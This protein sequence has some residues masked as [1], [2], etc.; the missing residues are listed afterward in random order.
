MSQNRFQFFR[1]LAA[2]IAILYACV[3]L[4]AFSGCNL[5]MVLL[6]FRPRDVF[7]WN[8]IVLGAVL[9]LL[10][11]LAA[12]YW[13]KYKAPQPTTPKRLLGLR[14]CYAAVWI[15]LA[16]VSFTADWTKSLHWV[17]INLPI[18]FDRV[19]TVSGTFIAEFSA[20]Y[21]VEIELERNLPIR[22]LESLTGSWVNPDHPAPS[23]PPRPEIKLTVT[24]VTPD[25]QSDSWSTDYWGTKVGLSLGRF[26]A[27][28][29]QKYTVT[30]KVTKTSPTTQV[31]NPHLLVALTYII[32]PR[33][34]VP[35]MIAQVGG[36]IALIVGMTLLIRAI[37]RFRRERKMNSITSL[38]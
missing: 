32:A 37:L 22:D 14:L 3:F 19:N 38:E 6:T 34:Y 36:M 20:A 24:N 27:V 29:G 9:G 23:S 25:D 21:Y 16:L 30:A 8:I 13:D 1:F 7:P 11:G 26:Q 10:A 18:R 5:G 17:P 33:Y 4:G 28:K 12:S 15:M 2:S 31:L 35:A